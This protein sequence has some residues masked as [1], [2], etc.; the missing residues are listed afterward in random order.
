MANT[1]VDITV[2]TYENSSISHEL[3]H[4]WHFRKANHNARVWCEKGS[5]RSHS[6]TYLTSIIPRCAPET[7]GTLA[8][9]EWYLL[10]VN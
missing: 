10:F 8:Q 3:I 6:L 4:S 9:R 2:F 7:E 5:I 1:K